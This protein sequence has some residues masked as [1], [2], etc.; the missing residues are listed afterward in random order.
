ML[1]ER[2]IPKRSCRSGCTWSLTYTHCR[3]TEEF[4]F[5]QHGITYTHNRGPYIVLPFLC[6]SDKSCHTQF[7]DTILRRSSMVGR[8]PVSKL[9]FIT[10]GRRARQTRI[11][12]LIV[13]G[14]ASKWE[15][16]SLC[17]CRPDSI[18]LPPSSLHL[19]LPSFSFSTNAPL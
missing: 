15:K 5:S 11:Y 7:T 16:V 4:I 18:S 19:H 12:K 1:E 13:K 14:S 10:P 17:V 2:V 9:N 8:L 6:V 3:K